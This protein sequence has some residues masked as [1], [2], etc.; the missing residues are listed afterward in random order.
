MVNKTFIHE[1]IKM[2]IE[3]SYLTV[4]YDNAVSAILIGIDRD[5]EKGQGV[6]T[7]GLGLV[8]LSSTFA[9]IAPP[10]VI[11]PIVAVI[12]A[13][14]AGYARINYHRM[15]QRLLSSMVALDYH[16]MAKL[17]TIAS[18]FKQYPMPSLIDS[19]NPAKNLVRTWKS[20]LGGILI[21]PFW[22]PIFYMMGM[23]IKEEANLGVL[24]QAII[25]VEKKLAIIPVKD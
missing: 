7:L 9:P 16:D 25:E 4:P 17:R 3:S 13:C 20:V 5:V 12:F 18:V 11:L 6:L 19:L 23:Q 2:T 24:S 22:M 10:T 8:M 1:G 15:E 14:S 21:N